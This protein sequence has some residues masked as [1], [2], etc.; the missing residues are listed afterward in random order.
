MSLLLKQLGQNKNTMFGNK[1]ADFIYLRNDNVI[2]LKLLIKK[3][4]FI[5]L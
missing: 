2:V 1:K 3:F 5:Y 4:T